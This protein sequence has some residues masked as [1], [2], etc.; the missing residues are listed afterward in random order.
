M[1]YFLVIPLLFYSL[2]IISQ[3]KTDYYVCPPCGLSCDKI[4]FDKAGRCHVCL[5]KLITPQQAATLDTGPLQGLKERGVFNLIIGFGIVQGLFLLFLLLLSKTGR[6]NPSNIYLALLILGIISGCGYY[7]LL[8]YRVFYDFPTLNL[9]PLK[10]FY[11]I[12]ASAYLYVNRSIGIIHSKRRILLHYSPTLI[13]ILISLILIISGVSPTSRFFSIY[14]IYVLGLLGHLHAIVY[15]KLTVDRILKYRKDLDDNL[16]IISGENSAWLSKL[17]VFASALL[18]LMTAYVLLSLLTP[19]LMLSNYLFFYWILAS[20]FVYWISISVYNQ[21]ALFQFSAKA[22][23]TENI[24]PYQI[25][26]YREAIRLSMERDKLF[27]DPELTRQVLADHLKINP[28]VLS[29][30]LNRHL[31]KS[32]YDFVNDYRVKEVQRKIQDPAYLHY[33]LEG[34]G[35]DSG[36]NSKST[37]NAMFKKI[38]GQT[39]RAYKKQIVSFK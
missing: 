5:M 25:N 30:I 7:L 33:T 24:D 14:D 1:R 16:S 12:G 37:F 22:T 27:L 39:P 15:F 4:E 2:D 23:Q 3:A 35:L 18:V 11:L 31:K 29:T 6:A 9:L 20:A 36:F 8:E 10:L 38:T 26:P 34:I 28:N 17:V 32:F 19:D 13:V 21:P